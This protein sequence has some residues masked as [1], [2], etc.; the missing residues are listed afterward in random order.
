MIETTSV[1]G[2]ISI[3]VLF[4]AGASDS[5][6]SSSIM[7]HC[8]LMSARQIDRWQV[9]LPTGFHVVVDSFNPSYE[10]DL[11]PFATS[12]DLQF[13]TL[14]SY[15]VVMGMDWLASHSAR[16]DYHQKIVECL[17]DHGR[18]VAIV[19][20]PRPISLC[21]IFSMKLKQCMH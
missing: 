9:E 3:S 16:V 15:G 4:D 7:E 17:D 2:G 20:I 21:M 19:G 11:G 14:R 1:L 6:I 10:L 12:V 18:K 8:G 5:F 13:I